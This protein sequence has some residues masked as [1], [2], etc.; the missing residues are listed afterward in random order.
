MFAQTLR[1]NIRDRWSVS[2]WGLGN[3]VVAVNRHV[4]ASPR[5][6]GTWPPPAEPLRWRGRRRHPRHSI[7]WPLA[8]A[9]TAVMR[10]SVFPI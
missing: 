7:P 1:T 5:I 10:F 4:L 2:T 6:W 9:A 8:V 3:V